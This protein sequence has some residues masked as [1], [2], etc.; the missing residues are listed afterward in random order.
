LTLTPREVAELAQRPGANVLVVDEGPGLSG[1]TFLAVGEALTAVGVPAERISL[2]CSHEF[3]PGQLRAENAAGR[4]GRFAIRAAAAWK[5]P[6]GTQSLAGGSWRALRCPNAASYPAC[7]ANLERVK[8][9]TSTGRT[10]VKFEGFGGY[11]DATWRRAVML[12][13]GG[14][15]PRV[16]RF[17]PGYFGYE[18]LEGRLPEARDR[19]WLLPRLAEYVTFRSR[20]LSHSGAEVAPLEHM[21]R[22]NVSEAFGIELPATVRLELVR[23]I[24]P[25]AR[26]SPHEWVIGAHG[27]VVKTDSADHASDHLMPGPADVAW[28]LAGTIV[29]WDLDR[30]QRHSFLQ[31]YRARSGDAAEARLP[32]YVA[33]YAAF[34]WV[35]QRW[36]GMR[37]LVPSGPDGSLANECTG[38]ACVAHCSSSASPSLRGSGRCPRPS[39][40]FRVAKCRADVCR[41]QDRE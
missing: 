19:S 12:A 31:E 29:E 8:Y 10:L 15:S 17:E 33:A 13:E 4:Y 28:D 11:A 35:L 27:R 40:P 34:D 9:R 14:W 5:Q 36:H 24:E 16:R 21:L 30:S 2:F 32:A 7:W 38:A 41:A 3:D 20:A 23:P 25:D 37:R 22:V 6:A 1:S 18:W 39:I 26:L